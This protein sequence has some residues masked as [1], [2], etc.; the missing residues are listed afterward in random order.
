MNRVVFLVDGFNVYHSL[1]EILR[2]QAGHSHKGSIK[3]LDLKSLAQSYLSAISKDASLDK[4][5][6][7]SALAK[8]LEAFKPDVTARHRLYVKCLKD[9]GVEV[10]LNR[11]KRK[12]ILCPYCKKAFSR[13]EEKE[14]DVSIAVKMMELCFLDLCDTMVLVT[15]DTDLHQ[16]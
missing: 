5:Y 7:F 9:S 10:E 14:S 15:G 8:H 13:H 6:Y 4:V 1:E 16:P 3:W 12:T 11:F 2:H